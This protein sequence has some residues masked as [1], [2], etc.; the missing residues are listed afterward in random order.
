MTASDARPDKGPPETERSGTH[1]S[2]EAPAGAL[3]QT[4]EAPE[5]TSEAPAQA[6]EEK[7]PA[8]ASTQTAEQTLA[9]PE[10]EENPVSRLARVITQKTGLSRDFSALGTGERAALARMTPDALKA[11][12][13]AA[14]AHALL[15]AKLDPGHWKPETWQRWALLAHGMALSGHDGRNPLGEQL[16]WADISESRVTT[17]LA[18]RG[19]ALRQRLPPFVRLLAKRRVA[20]NWNELGGLLLYDQRDEAKAE[21]LRIRI[22][23]RYFVERGKRNSA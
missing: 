17:L 6:P 10:P 8:Q 9:T 22:A 23:S 2:A 13:I 15:L 20:P 16:V 18:A 5:Q 7:A 21:A 4:S 3:A 11:H 12:Q 14:L 19:M 1:S